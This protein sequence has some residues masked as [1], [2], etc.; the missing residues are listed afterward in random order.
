[1]NNK[2]SNLAIFATPYPRRG[3]KPTL[4]GRIN[5]MFSVFREWWILKK[6]RKKCFEEDKKFVS[7]GQLDF[8]KHHEIREDFILGI[9]KKT[10]YGR[11]RTK[12]Q[13]ENRYTKDLR[14]LEKSRDRVPPFIKEKTMLEWTHEVIQRGGGD[15]ALVTIPN[16]RERQKPVITITGDGANFTLLVACSEFT[17]LHYVFFSTLIAILIF[18]STPFYHPTKDWVTKHWY[19]L[20]HHAQQE[21]PLLPR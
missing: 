12:N 17:S 7:Y 14:I 9:V 2:K 13:K 10:W 18:I 1:M 11:T 3:R 16:S 8:Q 4:W 19:N 21:I 6:L 20:T 15:V 5:H